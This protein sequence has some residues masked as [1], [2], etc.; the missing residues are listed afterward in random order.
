MGNVTIPNQFKIAFS[1]KSHSSQSERFTVIKN[2]IVIFVMELNRYISIFC[3][4][5]WLEIHFWLNIISSIQLRCKRDSST[6]KM[7]TNFYNDFY[8]VACCSK[9]TSS[10]SHQTTRG[11]W[12]RRI[13]RL[14]KFYNLF[15]MQ[16]WKQTFRAIYAFPWMQKNR[17]DK[18]IDESE[19]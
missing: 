11:T 2:S 7:F 19:L 17:K 1:I 3:T 8:A 10:C 12:N 15:Q 14:N 16:W 4:F 6:K 9:C 13:E 18:W 5:L